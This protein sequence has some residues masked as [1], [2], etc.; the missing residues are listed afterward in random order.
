MPK[1]SP[2]KSS[3]TIITLA[4]ATIIPLHER[5]ITP[6]LAPD[7]VIKILNA[8]TEHKKNIEK[9]ASKLVAAEHAKSIDI[10]KSKMRNLMDP[11]GYNT[12]YTKL[13]AVLPEEGSKD[14]YFTIKSKI[15]SEIGYKRE[16]NARGSDFCY[17]YS[18]KEE[19]ADKQTLYD[20][21]SIS[22]MSLKP[23]LIELDNTA[24]SELLAL[25]P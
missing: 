23:K 18:F 9:I 21:Y 12:F 11:D 25:I 24:S 17:Y 20:T 22:I 4:P 16:L 3:K 8:R 10:T 6:D 2:I 13:K 5:A 1:K 14:I 7:M 19:E 15:D